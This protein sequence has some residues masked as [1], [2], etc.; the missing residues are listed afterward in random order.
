[1]LG[2]FS[3]PN[4]R[5]LNA[6][7]L[8]VK[9]SE[10]GNLDIQI[11]SDDTEGIR[12]LNLALSNY[13]SALEY[14]LKNEKAIREAT[15]LEDIARR[16]EMQDKM[17]EENQKMQNSNL[18]LQLLIK[19]MNIILWDM[20]VDPLDPVGGNN[21]FSWS[22]EFRRAL[23]FSNERD[24]P[25]VLSSW[26]DRIHP[27]DKDAT[28][29]S[30]ADHLTDRTGRTPYN[31]TMRLKMKSGEY[32]IF[33]ACGATMRSRDGTPLHVAG[34]ITDITDKVASQ[35]QLDKNQ[36]ELKNNALRL[37]LLTKGMKI[38]LWDMVVD[39][40][41]PTGSNNEFW[42]SDDFRKALGFKNENDFP[43]VLSSWSDRIHPDDKTRALKNFADHLND[44][45][46]RTPY[47]QN[48]RLKTKSGEYRTFHAFGATL[49]DKDGT[50]LRVAGAINDITENEKMNEEL[51][52]SNLRFNLLLKSVDLALWEMTV[53]PNDPSGNSNEFWWSPEFRQMLGFKDE[54]D[55]PNVL[56]SW[57]DRLH[58]E[59]KKMAVDAF[60]AHV[61]D[62]SGRTPYNVEFR[63]KKKSGEYIW[64]KADGSTMRTP[65]GA[66]IRV[67]GSIENISNQLRKGELDSFIKEFTEEVQGMTKSV[68]KI[69]S[70][71][72]SLKKAQEQNLQTSLQAEK[73][74]AETKSIISSIKSIA[75]QTNLLALNA[76]V[77]AARAGEHGRGFAVVAEEV[78]GL[79]GNSASSAAQI[80]EKLSAIYESTVTITEDI[81]K[82][83]GL[84]DEQVASAAEINGLVDRLSGTY[85][86]L[87]NLVR[88]VNNLSV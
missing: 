51:Q 6:L 28:L 86:E 69:N 13:K 35:E 74:A 49:R 25:N 63:M 85:N 66:P 14:K 3:K 78:R 4:K 8:V 34:S 61:N 12:L 46:G 23:G 22:D 47:D 65:E 50:P 30:F 56:S 44:R 72:E 57:S 27:E 62:Y 2:I 82:T 39:P 41:D 70:A 45:T 59:D 88:S 20:Q 40:K 80:S 24:F 26:I 52:N 64:I 67:A 10:S 71:S 19:S 77:E 16:K 73:S 48:M 37:N 38:A 55:F 79:A 17:E 54:K 32:R 31:E 87:I 42:W 11:K 9:A 15:E 29:K 76:S 1:M 21:K 53:D 81:K 7:N 33:H 83:V 84:V 36:A 75:F 68:A 43:N 5:M 60:F 18:R 58:P